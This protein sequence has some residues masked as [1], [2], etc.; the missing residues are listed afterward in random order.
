M[1]WQCAGKRRRVRPAQAGR[2]WACSAVSKAAWS[3]G[4]HTGERHPYRAGRIVAIDGQGAQL[5]ALY[6]GMPWAMAPAYWSN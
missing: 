4:R 2:R 1:A 6:C 3:S 5:Y